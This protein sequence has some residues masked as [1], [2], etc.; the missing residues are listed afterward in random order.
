[1]STGHKHDGDHH[2]HDHDHEHPVAPMVEE[3][4][5]Y[6]VLEIAVRELAIEGCRNVT[7]AGAGGF[8]AGV[9][10]SYSSI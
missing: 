10:V 7:R 5:D 2:D 9:R 6:E 3:I 1:M 4:T 8:A